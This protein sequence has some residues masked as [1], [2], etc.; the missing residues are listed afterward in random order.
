M[1]ETKAVQRAA[2]LAVW[3]AEKKV[4]MLVA[5]LAEKMAA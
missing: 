4:A 1:A 5:L 3:K 2:L